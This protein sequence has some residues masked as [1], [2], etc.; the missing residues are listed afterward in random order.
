MDDSL[1]R[2]RRLGIRALESFL[3]IERRHRVANETHKTLSAFYDRDQEQHERAALRLWMVVVVAV[4]A[5]EEGARFVSWQFAAFLAVGIFAAP[6][7]FGWIG[8]GLQRVSA[9]LLMLFEAS[10]PVVC[11]SAV[12]LYLIKAALVHS[13]VRWLLVVW[14]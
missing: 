2:L 11:A 1:S 14:S 9:R 12:V 8:F 6:I 5:I 10:I 4:F 3:G 13:V 7:G